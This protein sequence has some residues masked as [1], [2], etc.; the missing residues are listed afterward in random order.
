MSK[1]LGN[2]TSLTDL[3]SRV[4]S[5]AYRLLV[6]QAHYRSPIEITS[7]STGRRG[8]GARAPRHSGP[9]LRCPSC[10]RPAPDGCAAA[11]GCSRHRRG[12]PLAAF[13]ARMDDDMDTPG[14]GRVVFEPCGGRHPAADYGGRRRAPRRLADAVREMLRRRRV[15]RCGAAIAST[16]AGRDP[17]AGGGTRRQS[18]RRRDY[19]RGRSRCAAQI[20]GPGHGPS[21]TDARGATARPALSRVP[22]QLGLAGSA[23]TCGR[24]PSAAGC[25]R[26]GC[27]RH[28]DRRAAFTQSRYT[29][30]AV[31]VTGSVRKRRARSEA[32]PAFV[33]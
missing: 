8:E 11:G 31:G 9:A 32:G 28:G 7:E 26:A 17:Q 10:P 18:A 3:L 13:R 20:G 6:L 30:A 15:W 1:S 29:V 33:D 27:I 12:R 4:D 21:R 25:H 22:L 5:R 19:R 16:S 2:F 23:T 14:G 24:A